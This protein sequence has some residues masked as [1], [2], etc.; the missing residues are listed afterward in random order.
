MKIKGVLYLSCIIMYMKGMLYIR[1]GLLLGI[2][3][4]DPFIL[5]GIPVC[6][7]AGIQNVDDSNS[8]ITGVLIDTVYCI[9]DTD[10]SYALYLPSGYDSAMSWPVV[11]IFEPGARGSMAAGIFSEASERFGI[12]IIASNNSSNRSYAGSRR[13]AAS[14]FRDAG[15]RFNVDSSMFFVAGFSG[16]SRMSFVLAEH[17]K[18]KDFAGVLAC[19]AGGRPE[20]LSSGTV[21]YGL[22]GSKCFNRWDM[23]CTFKG[24]RNKDSR[25][26]YFP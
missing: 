10:Q 25:L 8:L 26:R 2:L 5:E 15:M 13:A 4:C 1:L 7:D 23:A 11:F 22:C 16:G 19:G 14:M 3:L 6:P 20:K 24:I 9:L 18:S 17:R 21:V 12:I